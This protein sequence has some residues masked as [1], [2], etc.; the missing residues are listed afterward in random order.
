M[1]IEFGKFAAATNLFVRII[2]GSRSL[3][4]CTEDAERR[5]E[6]RISYRG[7]SLIGF[8][9]GLADEILKLLNDY[10]WTEDSR[11]RVNTLGYE[12]WWLLASP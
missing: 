2:P 8:R 12:F 5:R 10:D 11:F 7:S 6:T 4:L 9:R 3:T 1:E